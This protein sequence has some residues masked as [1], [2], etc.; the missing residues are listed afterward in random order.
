[1]RDRGVVLSI[2]SGRRR[3]VYKYTLMSQLRVV[4]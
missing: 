2:E 3:P 1:M 4:V